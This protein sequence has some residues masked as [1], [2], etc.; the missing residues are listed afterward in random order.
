MPPRFRAISTLHG[1][2]DLDVA[3]AIGAD[4]P[5][6][7]RP[8]DTIE[9]GHIGFATR[10]GT[11]VRFEVAGTAVSAEFSAGVAASLGVFPDHDAAIGALKLGET[12]GL[13]LS[14]PA[15]PD[16]RFAL[17][18]SSYTASGSVNG[19]H[20][21]GAVG[22][23][24]I[25]ASGASD[26]M[27]AVLH[28][29]QKTDGAR[30]VLEQTIASWALPRQ[31]TAATDLRPGTWLVAD[32]DGTLATNVVAALGYNMDFV[33]T[34]SAGTLAGDIGLKVDAAVST[35]FG[36]EV[37]GRYVVVVGRETS[38][39]RVRVQMFKLPR[40]GINFGVN[41]TV[42]VIGVET[43]APD[44]VDDFIAAVFGV[45]GAQIVSALKHL[46]DW[47]DPTKSVGE[48][49][50]GLSN[51]KAQELFKNLTGKDFR[52]EFD[53][54]RGKILNAIQQWENLGP[55]VSA[56]LWKLI[57]RRLS[58]QEI[59]VLNDSL[60]LLTATDDG[61]LR[62]AYASLLRDA[63]F[64][65]SPLAPLLNAAADRGLLALINR[66]NV[67]RSLATNVKGVLD[68]G[69]ITKLQ[70]YVDQKLRLDQ[71]IAVVNRADFDTLDSWLV[72]RLGVFFDK[73]L[74]FEDLNDIKNAINLALTAR[75]KIYDRVKDALN[76]RYGFDLAATWARTT[77]DTAVLD[78]EFDTTQ[79]EGKD[80]LA[81]LLQQSDIGRIL[82]AKSA[83]AR[84]RTGV[85][86]HELTRK[87]TVNISLPHVD[88][89]KQT[90]NQALSRI[91]VDASGPGVVAYQATG[92]DVDTSKNRFRS[93]LSVG[94]AAAVAATPDRADAVDIHSFDSTWSYEL[95]QSNTAM[96]RA[97]FEATT[98]PF[99]EK[100][101]LSQFAGA[102][103]LEDW[104]R[105]F[106]DSIEGKL[107]NGPS[108]FGDV[109]LSY[110]LTVP[111]AAL[112]AWFRP[113]AKNELKAS[114]RAIAIGIQRALKEVV[115][116]Y[117]L[118]D[119]R[120]VA[121]LGSSAVLL[122][123]ASIPPANALTGGGVIWDN[124]DN[125]QVTMVT[126]LAVV[127]LAAR[128]PALQQRLHDAGLDSAMQFYANDQ[129]GSI[130]AGVLRPGAGRQLLDNLLSFERTIVLS[131]SDAFVE[132]QSFL[133][134]DSPADALD[135]LADFASD[136]TRTFNSHAGETVFV[137]SA[138][139]PLA[140]SV[141]VEAARTLDP[142]V[143]ARPSAMLT[144]SV[145]NPTRTFD[146]GRFLDGEI[147]PADQVVVGQRLVA[148]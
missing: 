125:K 47:T 26:G 96:R 111:S 48:I 64:T 88:L 55:K 82:R 70:Q 65:T 84:I 28:G 100:F 123:W 40:N 42:G 11:P 50:A 39:E 83:A 51:D 130:V 103:K 20:P 19:R 147:P 49:V 7:E 32:V 2:T 106:D 1:T 115:S 145:L 17:L 113:V 118:A 34:V 27:I 141:F 24:A 124:R 29:F 5:F 134:A 112:A 97:D 104:Y 136:I 21:I 59:Q 8:G 122:T 67:V 117:Y 80:L 107:H 133:R 114:A 22:S 81:A 72:G 139:R 41:L 140:Q 68:G 95:L 53:A 35:T 138:F 105:L 89:Q 37:S 31:V 77:A 121:N 86:T 18:S 129:A 52:Q 137:G 33:R 62:T 127:L 116:F 10:A 16:T 9:L 148:M 6:P 30:T 69:V 25:S 61:V 92:Q 56:E 12:P 144:V 44:R 66:P 73:T 76:S 120:R 38:D 94:V 99:L 3:K 79:E 93:T 131:A 63:G 14:V 101:M 45:H 98:R 58:D 36:L 13:D 46:E 57:G 74:H 85:L 132:V 4:A 87:T 146:I 108:V 71:V 23:V 135:R 15:T 109:C 75:K 60:T 78:V 43:V 119:T 90:I 143:A 128:L 142:T 102:T 110:E 54:V 126:N 91:D